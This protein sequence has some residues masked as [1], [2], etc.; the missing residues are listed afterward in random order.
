MTRPFFTRE[1]ISDFDI[2]DRNCDKALE[3][4]KDRL[5]QGHPIEF[6]VTRLI[7]V[8][9]STS[10]TNSFPFR[11]LLEDLLW[12]L[13]PSSCLATTLTLFLLGYLILP[14]WNTRTLL[15]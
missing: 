9:Q 2:Y 14:P 7:H 11:I 1:R 13:P 3:A 5:R 4:A 8:Q 12:I 6:Q 10:N 15:H